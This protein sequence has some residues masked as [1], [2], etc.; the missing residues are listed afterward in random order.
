MN[1]D[2]MDHGSEVVGNTS[3]SDHP[4]KIQQSR[5]EMSYDMT[6]RGRCMGGSSVICVVSFGH[7]T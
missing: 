1:N 2:Q 3:T 6:S 5:H 7:M 4:Y